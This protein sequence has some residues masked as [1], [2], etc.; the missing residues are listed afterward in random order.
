MC[1]SDG[2]DVFS[3][4]LVCSVDSLLVPVCPVNPIFKCCDAEWVLES[5]RRIKN[6]SPLAAIIVTWWNH[7][8][9]GIHPVYTFA[10]KVKCQP[11]RPL[12][13]IW[14]NYLPMRSIHSS[15][16]YLWLNAPVSP[17]HPPGQ[18]IL[19]L[20]KSIKKNSLSKPPISYVIQTLGYSKNYLISVSNWLTLFSLNM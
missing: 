18:T 14:D 9:L 2:C 8:Q 5:I 1:G 20:P 17:K 19:T 15:S 10:Y 16:F 7:I 12:H 13:F 3:I 6:Y 4:K 11:I